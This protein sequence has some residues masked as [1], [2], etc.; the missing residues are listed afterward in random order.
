MLLGE[1]VWPVAV[2][3]EESCGVQ[4]RLH[5][6]AAGL[7]WALSG[8]NKAA[9]CT[10]RELAQAEPHGEGAPCLNRLSCFTVPLQI[11]TTLLQR[12]P[13]VHGH[14]GGASKAVYVRRA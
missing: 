4:T 5:A 8:N 3:C 2:R 14:E 10:V 1:R 11:S 12:A 7:C 9:V 6:S 13:R